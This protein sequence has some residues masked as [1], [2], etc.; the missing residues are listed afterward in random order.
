MSHLQTA[1]PVLW[2]RVRGGDMRKVKITDLFFKG[3]GARVIRTALSPVL[4]DIT[5]LEKISHLVTAPDVRG[6]KGHGKN[7][8]S[9]ARQKRFIYGVSLL[10]IDNFEALGLELAEEHFKRYAEEMAAYGGRAGRV[11]LPDAPPAAFELPPTE[12]ESGAFV[13]GGPP[14]LAA[15]SGG[16]GGGGGGAAAAS[17][18]SGA[19]DDGLPE[20]VGDLNGAVVMF[21]GKSPTDEQVA[22][23][24]ERGGRVI[25]GAPK[26]KDPFS[27]LVVKHGKPWRDTPAG[28]FARDN[29]VTV[30]IFEELDDV[31]LNDD[32]DGGDDDDGDELEDDDA[33]AASSAAAAASS[34]SAAAAAGGGSAAAASSSSA[35]AAAASAAFFFA[36]FDGSAASGGGGSGAAAA[37]AAAAT[38]AA[39]FFPVPR[40]GSHDDKPLLG[41]AAAAAAAAEVLAAPFPSSSARYSF[42]AP[43]ASGIGGY[44][45]S[46][47]YGGG[48]GGGSRG[49]VLGS[50]ARRGRVP[51]SGATRGG[52]HDDSEAPGSDSTMTG[53]AA[54]VDGGGSS[55]MSFASAG[56]MGPASRMP[57]P[58]I[59]ASGSSAVAAAAAASSSSSSVAAAT[60][61]TA[62][63]ASSAGAKRRCTAVMDAVNDDGNVRA[64]AAASSMAAMPAPPASSGK[65]QC[66]ACTTRNP[67]KAKECENCLLP[68]AAAALPPPAAPPPRSRRRRLI[69]DDDDDE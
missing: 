20:W 45:G 17:Q 29:G 63:A 67:S 60:A 1:S 19:G 69:V 59:R 21:T 23:I 12:K 5:Q 54:S 64:A 51:F 10:V 15:R 65:W 7:G 14:F 38:A 39:S 52:W 66:V 37:A 25:Y 2:K 3:S 55:R 18:S 13:L 31:L 43:R 22:G 42:H 28:V 26:K 36:D 11:V 58:P 6:F 8:G 61:A 34:S 24:E 30:I 40:G 68:R 50:S 41:A 44:G 48:S 56:D 33:A 9:P 53:Q 4:A 57:P 47:G 46:G 35:A 32:D 49:S 16:G 62:A 27:L